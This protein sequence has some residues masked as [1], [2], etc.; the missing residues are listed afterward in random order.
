MVTTLRLLLLGSLITTTLSGCA[1]SKSPSASA[2]AGPADF[3]GTWMGGTATGTKEMTLRLQQ[4]GTN[5]TGTLA[6]VGAPD[7]PINGTVGGDTIQLSAQRGAFAP[8]LVIRG[9]LMN[10]VLDGV[11]LNLVRFNGPAPSSR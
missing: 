2:S 10:G 9:D 5:V 6:G 3:S 1:G 7:G 8:R 11:P 4:T